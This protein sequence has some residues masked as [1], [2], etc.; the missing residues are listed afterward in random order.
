[1]NLTT[2]ILTGSDCW[3]AGRT[4]TPKGVMVHSTG[5]AQPDPE[6]FLKNWNQP[7][8]EACAHGQP[9]AQDT[10]SGGK[11]K[12]KHWMPGFPNSGL[13]TEMTHR[14]GSL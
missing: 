3:K 12:R 13:P 5:V 14:A 6:V 9:A 4:I 1:M 8:V 11:S 10:A 7:G 2:R